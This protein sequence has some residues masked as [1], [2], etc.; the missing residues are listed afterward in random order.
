MAGSA[1]SLVP[2]ITDAS[3]LPL[4][5]R[6]PHARGGPTIGRS[7]TR[8]CSTISNQHGNP[9]EGALPLRS[10]VWG[11]SPR[12]WPHSSRYRSPETVKSTRKWVAVYTPGTAEPLG[13]SAAVVPVVCAKSYSLRTLF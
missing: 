13:T 12:T 8:R 5:H 10:G 1:R 9:E 3:Q 7:A 4:L 2:A 6:D 11:Q